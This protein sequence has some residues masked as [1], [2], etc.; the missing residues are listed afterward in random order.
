MRIGNFKKDLELGQEI[1]K[2]AQ[3]KL[4]N[5]LNNNITIINTNNDFK[6]DFKLS[7]NL[8]Y[9]VKYDR[10]SIITG[11]IFIEFY[12]R[13]KLSGISTSESDF[14]IIAYTDKD[15]YLIETETLK[16]LINNKEYMRP[17]EDAIKSGYLFKKNI[18]TLNS[19]KL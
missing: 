13:G 18:I 5:H 12:C 8:K 2:I 3:E 10:M 15:L 11:N 9:E 6:Y 7:N 4:I 19:T 1:E 17:Y 14:Y 16:K